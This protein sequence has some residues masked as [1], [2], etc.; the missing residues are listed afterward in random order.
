M[1]VWASLHPRLVPH[2]MGCPVPVLDAELRNASQEFFERT[3]AWREWLP[4]ITMV[5]GDRTYP[6]APPT[7]SFVVR[8]EKATKNG[9][10]LEVQGAMTLDKDP[11]LHT[12]SDEGMSSADRASIVMSKDVTAGDIIQVQASLAPTQDSTGIPD[13]LVLHYRDALVAG[14]LSRIRMLPGQKF[15]DPK[16]AA[17]NLIKF[18]SEIDRVSALVWRSHTN[19]QPRRRPLWC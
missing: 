9:N 1:A 8:L 19:N 3:R 16:L 7:G 10:P 18:T 13:A 2:V 12:T 5:T 11:L 15:F 14:A 6:L 4:V 17:V